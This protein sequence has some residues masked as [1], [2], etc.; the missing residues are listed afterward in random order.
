MSRS[1]I[2]TYDAQIVPLLRQM[3]QLEE[4]TLSLNVYERRA[5]IEGTHLKMNILSQMSHLKTF[6]FDIVTHTHIND[7]NLKTIDDIQST[8]VQNVDGYIDYQP[9]GNS[10]CHIYSLP[11]TM[12]YLHDITNNFPGGIFTNVRTLSIFDKIHPFEHDFFNRISH[13]FPL[14]NSLMV[15]NLKQQNEKQTRQLFNNE[16]RFS[17]I[18]FSRLSQLNLR[19]AHFDYVE[20]FLLHTNTYLPCLNQLEI[21]YE[22]LVNLT[23]NFKNNAPKVN[24][25]KLKRLLLDKEITYSIDFYLYFPLLLRFG[26]LDQIIKF[27]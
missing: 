6:I 13:S 5:F 1:K 27:C 17:I 4:L 23:E 7:E 21:Q 14:L 22:H 12:E 20:Q 3:T 25:A 9:N 8:F 10:R 15:F 2:I 16:K 11:F 24:C 18:E 26:R 19:D